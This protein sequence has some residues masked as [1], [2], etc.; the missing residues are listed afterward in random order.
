M[1]AGP[2]RVYIPYSLHSPE[3]SRANT[4]RNQNPVIITN[5]PSSQ[6]AGPHITI[7]PPK[8]VKPLASESKPLE[9]KAPESKPN[10]SNVPEPVEPEAKAP[11]AKSFKE[12]L[13]GG[14]GDGDKQTDSSN[15]ASPSSSQSDSIMDSSPNTS[16]SNSNS[17]PQP[18]KEETNK[19]TEDTK[20]SNKRGEQEKDTAD[21]PI[22]SK[23]CAVTY[24]RLPAINVSINKSGIAR[25]NVVDG[26]TSDTSMKA[27][28]E[29]TP[30]QQHILFWDRDRDGQIYPYDTY[31]GFRDLGFNILFSFLA[32]LVINLNFSYPTRLAHSFLPDS[33]FRVYVDSIYKAKHGSDSGSFDAEGCFVPQHF[34]DMFAKY[35]GDQDGALTIGELFKMMHGN[36][37]AADPFGVRHPSSVID[38]ARRC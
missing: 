23:H 26:A 22:V 25:C 11:E 31:R 35:D 18:A 21:I 5:M 32:M 38:E 7:A 3:L 33:R 10:N 9:P 37:C 4:G 28:H 8:A 30:M 16:Q 29:F 34:E 2:G 12:A 1:M 15:T 14:G 13:V 36:R 27:F 24:K 17:S 19:N 6:P 20:E